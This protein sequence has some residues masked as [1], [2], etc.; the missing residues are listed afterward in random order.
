MIAETK[1]LDYDLVSLENEAKN[2]N[3]AISNYESVENISAFE[4]D[5]MLNLSSF[6]NSYFPSPEYKYKIFQKTNR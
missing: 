6:N 3:Q 5:L 4:K 2:I 1:L